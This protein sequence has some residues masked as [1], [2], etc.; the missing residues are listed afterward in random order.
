MTDT[1][2]A[3]PSAL[4]YAPPPRRR[5]LLRLWPA[6]VLLALAGLAIVYGPG[7][8]RHWKLMR[9]QSACMTAQLP[10]DRPMFLGDGA[11]RDAVD[12]LAARAV[13]YQPD[14]F[15][16]AERV[17]AR[18]AALAAEVGVPLRPHTPS[19]YTWA[20]TFCHER[21][22]PDGRRRLV[23]V[24]GAFYA[25]VIEPATWLGGRP[26]VLWRGWTIQDAES[27]AALRVAASRYLGHNRLDGG[28]PDPADRSRFTVRFEEG[29]VPG[30]WEHRLGDDD[31][32][33]TRMTDPAGFAARAKA[34]VPP[35]ERPDPAA[36]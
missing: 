3:T 25:T 7:A 8:W 12:L 34:F 24:E 10:T 27:A 23:V 13:E 17:D 26:R 31:R 20:T 30:M 6:A 22:T 28:T 33:T 15:G 9:L 14:E 4:D 1:T 16:Q 5:V 11:N 18:W 35:W 21:H 36:P 32:V 29:L 19:W 2:R